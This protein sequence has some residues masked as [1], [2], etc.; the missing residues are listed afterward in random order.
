MIGEEKGWED[1]VEVAVATTLTLLQI[2]CMEVAVARGWS[3][4]EAGSWH[5]SRRMYA[6][7]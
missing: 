2:W 1:A 7:V 5:S 3:D 6:D 4:T